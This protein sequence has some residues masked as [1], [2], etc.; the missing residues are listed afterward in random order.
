MQKTWPDASNWQRPV[1]CPRGAFGSREK[2]SVRSF[3]Y[4]CTTHS[5]N[6]LCFSIILAHASSPRPR[7]TTWTAFTG[8]SWGRESEWLDNK[9]SSPLYAK[10]GEQPISKLNWRSRLLLFGHVMYS[11]CRKR[12][13]QERAWHRTSTHR[14]RNDGDVHAPRCQVCYTVILLSLTVDTYRLA[15]ICS[16]WQQWQTIVNNGN[17]LAEFAN[18]SWLLISAPP[19]PSRLPT[20]CS[21][22]VSRVVWSHFIDTL[23]DIFLFLFFTILTLSH[24]LHCFGDLL[25]WRIMMSS[26]CGIVLCLLIVLFAFLVSHSRSFLLS[27]PDEY[28]TYRYSIVTSCDLD[29]TG[30]SLRFAVRW[31][32]LYMFAGTCWHDLPIFNSIWGPCWRKLRKHI[33]PLAFESPL[34]FLD[35][36]AV[37]MGPVQSSLTL[38]CYCFGLVQV[39]SKKNEV[40]CD[41]EQ[42]KPCPEDRETLGRAT[43]SFLHTMTAYYPD[44]PSDRKQREARQFMRL[45]SHFYPCDDCAEHLQV[46]WGAQKLSTFEVCLLETFVLLV[47]ENS[48][49]C[50]LK[51]QYSL[52]QSTK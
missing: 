48:A 18:Q 30:A 1:P 17:W 26:C 25:F 14:R 3:G 29:G 8:D 37:D 15:W 2:S 40:S 32:Y 33:S 35:P 16:I 47:E 49:R 51:G 38:V 21:T 11:D 31:G 19:P 39:D 28:T 52:L 23:I 6:Y 36:P 10:Y 27:V 34:K 42:L 4:A 50:A 20:T 9:G 12:H 44:K 13:Q 45:F 7:R 41:P 43:W 24:S 5:P 22:V 46:W